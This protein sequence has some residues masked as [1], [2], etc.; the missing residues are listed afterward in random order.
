MDGDGLGDIYYDI[1]GGTNKDY[2]PV[3]EPPSVFD[4]GTGTSPSI[5]GTHSGMI[6]M[7]SHV[8]VSHMHTYPCAGTGGHA[9]S[10][11][12]WN[13]TWNATATWNDYSGD[14]HNITFDESFILRAGGHTI[15]RS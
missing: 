2:L 12:I 1:S 6:V 9:E 10:V 13:S 3:V 4:T 11:K 7:S 15:T 14:Y 5:S 8:N